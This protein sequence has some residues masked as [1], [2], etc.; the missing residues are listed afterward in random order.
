MASI[1]KAGSNARAQSALPGHRPAS[2][3]HSKP[4]E[5]LYSLG[6]PPSLAQLRQQLSRFT[7]SFQPEPNYSRYDS[8]RDKSD[9]IAILEGEIRRLKQEGRE[10]GEQIRDLKRILREKELETMTKEAQSTRDLE[11]LLEDKDQRIVELS[12]EVERLHGGV[13]DKEVKRLATLY[14]ASEQA[15]QQTRT[16][17]EVLSNRLKTLESRPQ[18]LGLY[19]TL[20][21]F[22][23][24]N[25][26]LMEEVRRLQGQV[27]SQT[28]MSTLEREFQEVEQMQNKLITD[29]GRLKQEL[30]AQLQVHHSLFTRVTEACSLVM[31]CRKDLSQLTEVIRIVRKGEGVSAALI[32]GHVSQS[33]HRDS[34]EE[35]PEEAVM[36]EARTLKADLRELRQF[37]SDIY[38]EQS[39]HI[40]TQQ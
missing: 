33:E 26:R 37:L 40:C 34:V 16:D 30:D 5:V 19:E 12:E 11:S 31:D 27:L 25:K 29:N 24:E 21:R 1:T 23:G 8:L 32:L 18:D 22:Q 35:Q 13:V 39:G 7:P 9:S 17:L 2:P 3:Q 10:K 36:R 20:G 14:V 28:S 4:P 6:D 38:A 15:L